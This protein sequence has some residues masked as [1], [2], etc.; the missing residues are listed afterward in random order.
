MIK[1][2]IGINKNAPGIHQ[3]R[4]GARHIL[5]QRNTFI[6]GKK[7]FQKD[8]PLKPFIPYDRINSRPVK[9]PGIQHF[10]PQLFK[11]FFCIKPCCRRVFQNFLSSVLLYFHESPSHQDICSGLF[12]QLIQ[13]P[14]HSFVDPV[15]AVH[16]GNIF[17]GSDPCSRLACSDKTTVFLMNDPDPSVLFCV[18]VANFRTSVR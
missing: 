13:G 12:R 5:P 8:V 17:S 6:D 3:A 14:I 11:L 10:L 4:I 18:I 15:V 2:L 9:M 16:K 7:I 1:D